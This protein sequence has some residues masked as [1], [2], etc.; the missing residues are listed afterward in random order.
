MNME[1]I[2]HIIDRY[3]RLRSLRELRQSY[4]GA[5]AFVGMGHHST[6]NLYPVLSHLH[7]PLKYICCK[8]PSKLPL[9]ER[10][11]PQVRATTS[12]NEILADEAVKG[13]FVS[14]APKAQFS[15][16]SRVLEHQKALFVEKPPCLSSEELMRLVALQKQAHVTAVVDLQKRSAPAMQILKRELRG[17]KGAT[18]Y[19]LR[20]LTGAYPEGDALLDLFIHPLDCATYLFGIAEVR[21]AEIVDGHT[22]MLMLKHAHATGVM[23]LST[24]YSWANAHESMM[25]NTNKGV[26][27]WEQMDSL[28][29]QRKPQRVC[30][31]PM[32]KV[33]AHRN[34][35]TEL[36]GRNHFLPLVQ[37]NQ[38]VA[39]GY[40]GAIKGFVDAVEG[41]GAA[42]AQSLETYA[43]TYSLI[44]SIRT[45]V[46]PQ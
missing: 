34:V 14:V 6:N 10:A 25:L 22:L 46:W 15:I 24:G 31:V 38:I 16:A 42:R 44:D 39:Q 35:T 17:C 32:E 33:F 7:V 29:F 37:N 27:T 19:N 21:G 3:K 8:S 23:E 13:V 2:Q 41:R 11:F 5:Y 12:L 9:I 18:T 4:E 20:Y 28:T 40:Y 43:D 26:Y 30:G 45:S 1:P 36:F